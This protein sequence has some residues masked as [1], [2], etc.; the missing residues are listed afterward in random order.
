M[1]AIELCKGGAAGAYHKVLWNVTTNVTFDG[2][3]MAQKSFVGRSRWML[4]GCALLH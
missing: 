1:G 2:H 3:P 4:N